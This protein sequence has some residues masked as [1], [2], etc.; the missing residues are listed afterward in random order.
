MKIGIKHAHYKK[1]VFLWKE[2]E[3]Q[4]N[5]VSNEYKSSYKE[6]YN[7]VNLLSHNEKFVTRLNKIRDKY[8]FNEFKLTEDLLSSLALYDKEAI[9]KINE[10]VEK[11][12]NELFSEFDIDRRWKYLFKDLIIFGYF[13]LGDDIYYDY[14]MYVP[15]EDRFNIAIYHPITKNQFYKSIDKHW[16]FINKEIKKLSE[17]NNP[18]ISDRDYKI[19]ELRD[20][21]KMKYS[22]IA[23]QIV[24]EYGIDDY[25][26]SVNEDSIKTA[27][28][29]TKDKINSINKKVTTT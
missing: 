24:K 15:S 8:L 23:T 17:F 13:C 6:F 21:K 20:E 22:E 5:S 3:K 4:I 28:K 26:G 14:I 1:P 16:E 7:F 25:T 12:E 2:L 19:V 9:K 10:F 27:Y 29:R 18:Y 11:A